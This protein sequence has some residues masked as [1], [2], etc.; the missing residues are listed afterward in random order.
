MGEELV[1]VNSSEDN[2]AARNSAALLY[3]VAAL[4]S[5]YEIEDSADFAKRILSLMSSKAGGGVQDAAVEDSVE[6]E[7]NEEKLTTEEE[8]EEEGV[9]AV[10]VEAVMEEKEEKESV[11]VEAD[12]KQAKTIA[13]EVSDNSEV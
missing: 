7:V 5:G 11:T 4:T 1:K 6:K 10:E 12:V 9:T 2:V 13:P 3:D 8:E